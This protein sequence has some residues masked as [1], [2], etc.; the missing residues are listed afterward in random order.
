MHIYRQLVLQQGCSVSMCELN[1]MN[2]GLVAHEKTSIAVNKVVSVY[3][4]GLS[5]E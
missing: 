5:L 1:K 4:E 2:F 3:S